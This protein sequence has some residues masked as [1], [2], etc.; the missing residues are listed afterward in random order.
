[1]DGSRVQAV[2]EVATSGNVNQT[3]RNANNSVQNIAIGSVENTGGVIST[4]ALVTGNLNQSV[5]G[6]RANQTINLGSVRNSNGNITTDVVVTGRVSQSVLG[7][8]DGNQRVLVGGVEGA[9]QAG[10]VVN[11]Q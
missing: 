3:A 5:D 8:N 2:T 4:R 11:D 6:G 7:S 10:S 9:Q 1:M